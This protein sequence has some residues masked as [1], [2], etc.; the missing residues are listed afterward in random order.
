[1]KKIIH[2]KIPDIEKLEPLE[3][4][5][6]HDNLKRILEDDYIVITSPFDLICVDGDIKIITIDV[7]L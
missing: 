7:V 5:M 4:K 3:I 1:M 6:W 2:A